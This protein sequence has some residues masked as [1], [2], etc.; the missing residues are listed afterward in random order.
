M[1]PMAQ[2]EPQNDGHRDCM[3]V[4]RVN[5]LVVSALPCSLNHPVPGFVG[6][7]ENTADR[8]I[9][10]DKNRKRI[11][12]TLD[13]SLFW[14]VLQNTFFFVPCTYVIKINSFEYWTSMSVFFRF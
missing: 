2:K 6:S 4:G 5:C 14:D 7:R 10:W 9:T 8:S 11:A 1:Q 12:P 3:T 13:V